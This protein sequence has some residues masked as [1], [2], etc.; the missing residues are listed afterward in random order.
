MIIRPYKDDDYLKVLDLL[1]LCGVEPPSEQSD[2]KGVCLVAEED[3]LVIGCIWALVGISSQ[4]HVD[5]FAVKPKYRNT[6]TALNLLLQL[7]VVLKQLGVKRYS[8]YV[9]PDNHEFSE[10]IE[11]CKKQN[12]IQRL[13]ELLFYRR[14]I[15]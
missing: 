8:F 2:F 14:E 9:E 4:A 11:R 1:Q 6:H 13:R 5:F 15:T 12:K 3:S 7:D 10:L